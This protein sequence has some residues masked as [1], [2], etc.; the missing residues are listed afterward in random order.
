MKTCIRASAPLTRDNSIFSLALS[1]VR[2]ASTVVSSAESR[3]FT[4]CWGNNSPCRRV[5]LMR[6]LVKENLSLARLRIVSHTY[7]MIQI[8][9]HYT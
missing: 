8:F 1:S 5:A 4:L 7:E 3:D 2:Y 9:F 6:C